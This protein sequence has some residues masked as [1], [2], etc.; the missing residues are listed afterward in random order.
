MKVFVEILEEYFVNK[1]L[2]EKERKK[3]IIK[4]NK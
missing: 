3:T 2:N 1:T 4:I